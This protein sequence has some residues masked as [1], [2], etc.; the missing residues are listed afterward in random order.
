MLRS[1][2]RQRIVAGFGVHGGQHL[3]DGRLIVGGDLCGDAAAE[4]Y[5]P[6]FVCRIYYESGAALDVVGKSDG[7]APGASDS[8]AELVS[9]P[10]C[11][12]K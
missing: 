8:S 11:N 1:R 9:S 10:L 7:D 6:R 4:S 3:Q 12:G 2:H 5:G